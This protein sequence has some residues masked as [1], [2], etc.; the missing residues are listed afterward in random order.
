M[1]PFKSLIPPIFGVLWA[2]LVSNLK[3][4]LEEERENGNS[5]HQDIEAS[6]SDGVSGI[7]VGKGREK[8][9]TVMQIL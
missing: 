8:V 5:N 9:E 3:E 4:S 7:L 6:T 2:L 1:A